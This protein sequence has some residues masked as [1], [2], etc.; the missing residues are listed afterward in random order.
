MDDPRA[1]EALDV[2]EGER[3]VAMIQI[4]EPASIPE[5]KPRRPVEEVT[6]WLP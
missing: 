6:S 3:I 2:P 4:G 5:A 1:R